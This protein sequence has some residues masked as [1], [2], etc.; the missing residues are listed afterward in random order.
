MVKIDNSPLN[1]GSD[2]IIKTLGHSAYPDYATIGL[3]ISLPEVVL[4]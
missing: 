2:R 3:T 4:S 1:T